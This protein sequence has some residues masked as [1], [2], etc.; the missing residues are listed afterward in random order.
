MGCDC[1][2]TTAARRDGPLFLP[3]DF[4]DVFAADTFA[5]LDF[6]GPDFATVL[7][8]ALP[9]DFGAL[10]A[11]AFG[12]PFFEMAFFFIV[13]FEVCGDA[14]HPPKTKDSERT[15]RMAGIRK[16]LVYQ[17]QKS[18]ERTSLLALGTISVQDQLPGRVP[19]SSSVAG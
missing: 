14:A 11:A 13:D 19:L 15:A 7:G 16:F 12:A 2:A 5:A 9:D 10:F 3:T 6:I 4:P 8:A 18:Q 1:R 17:Q